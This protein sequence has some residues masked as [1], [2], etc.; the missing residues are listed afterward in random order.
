MMGRCATCCGRIQKV[1]HLCALPFQLLKYSCA[2]FL[3]PYPLVELTGWGVSPR[4]AGFLFGRDITQSF[5]FMNNL[6]LVARAHQLVM[7]GYKHMHNGEI[8][9]VWSAPKW[10]S[11]R[12]SRQLTRRSSLTLTF[13]ACSSVIATDAATLLPFSSLTRTSSRS[14]SRLMLRRR[15]PRASRQSGRYQNIVRATPAVTRRQ[16]DAQLTL[17]LFGL[18]PLR[19]LSPV[20]ACRATSC[21]HTCFHLGR[22]ADSP[23]VSFVRLLCPL[24]VTKRTPFRRNHHVE[25]FA[26]PVLEILDS[27]GW[28]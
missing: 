6:D 18:S 9:T 4:G 27:L 15:R 25:K 23:L 10:V 1:C 2:R 12:A 28:Q 5:N 13:L 22:S 24:P 17:C 26:S 8:V 19:P 21:S 3:C 16:M 20:S 14:T 11:R 7:E